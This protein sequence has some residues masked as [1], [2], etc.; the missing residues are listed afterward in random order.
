MPMAGGSFP[1][2]L[3]GGAVMATAAAWCAANLYFVAVHPHAC[4]AL[5]VPLLA[6]FAGLGL[7]RWRWQLLLF[8]FLAPLLYWLPAMDDAVRLRLVKMIFPVV[9][10]FWGGRLVAPGARPLPATPTMLP[11]FLYMGLVLLSALLT[12]W[13]YEPLW[14]WES[15]TLVAHDLVETN[16]ATWWN[17]IRPD[18]G[19][20]RETLVYLSGP[21]CFLLLLHSADAALASRLRRT[22]LCSLAIAALVALYQK[23][24]GAPSLRLS[25]WGREGLQRVYGTLGDAN[26]FGAYLALLLPTLLIEVLLRWRSARDTGPSSTRLWLSRGAALGAM[27]LVVA[28]LVW[29]ASRA[30]VVG[31][32]VALLWGA[33]AW[34]RDTARQRGRSPGL[35]R[36]AAGRYAA[37][38]CL[39][40]GAAV[41]LYGGLTAV[42]FK[43]WHSP[44]NAFLALFNPDRLHD[45]IRGRW[46]WWS[47]ALRMGTELPLTGVGIGQYRFFDG[48]YWPGPQQFG[49]L[50]DPHNTYLKPFAELGVPGLALFL[51]ICWAVWHASRARPDSPPGSRRYLRRLAVGA[52]LLALAVDMLFQHVLVQIE[53]QVIGAAI[54]ALAVLDEQGQRPGPYGGLKHRGLTLAAAGIAAAAICW[55]GWYRGS[56]V[57][58]VAPA[59]MEHWDRYTATEAGVY[60]RGRAGLS[61]NLEQHLDRALVVVAARAEK[62]DGQW[63]RLMLE[64]N[65]DYVTE[66]PIDSATTK[67][68][69]RAVYTTPGSNRFLVKILGYYQDP[70][71]GAERSI[72]VDRLTVL[73]GHLASHF[74]RLEPPALERDLTSL[75]L[76][77]PLEPPR[78]PGPP[79]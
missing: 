45:E 58:T 2:R 52:G 41:A 12:W 53:M 21:L 71:S 14:S 46:L 25:V 5:T 55:S 67:L 68:F 62:V 29:T 1:T 34:W 15:V 64:V 9:L 72:Y 56:T 31:A 16:R 10:L 20:V 66:W 17:W 74:D 28:A 36:T 13:R 49:I 59:T 43:E 7:L 57:H 51:W 47:P 50:G 44:A 75:L 73:G 23:F 3:F 39:A 11:L 27:A 69:T 70:S 65:G 77:T 19:I 32:A 61:R 26:T 79:G 78:R 40:A 8:V 76:H 30:A 38:A 42:P 35:L 24:S 22:L 4:R 6:V 37:V 18:F 54:A 33:R 60:L 48:P 63:P